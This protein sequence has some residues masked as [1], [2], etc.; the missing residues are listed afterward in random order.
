[1]EIGAMGTNAFTMLLQKVAAFDFRA[2]AAF[3]GARHASGP[4]SL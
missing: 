3:I 2:D 4:V 1:L